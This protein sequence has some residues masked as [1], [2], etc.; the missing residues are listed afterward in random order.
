MENYNHNMHEDKLN[1]NG[2]EGILNICNDLGILWENPKTIMTKF[3]WTENTSDSWLMHRYKW[4]ER[5][6][7]RK[8]ENVEIWN[9]DRA[10]ARCMYNWLVISVRG[11]YYG[12]NIDSHYRT[13]EFCQSFFQT[14]N[15]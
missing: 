11:S 1:E 7:G 10:K 3:L 13:V 15:K 9:N 6:Y 4:N 12:R 8:N 5:K 14:K 2:E